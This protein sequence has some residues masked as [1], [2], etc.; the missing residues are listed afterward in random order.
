MS[1]RLRIDSDYPYVYETHLHT[2]EGSKCA[3]STGKEMADACFEA[4]YTG[5]MVT[6]HFYY[7]NTAID[8][9]L[10]W[11]DWV[12]EYCR[13]YEN[14][15]EEGDK[16]GLQV[17]FGWESTY[18]GTDFLIYGLDKEWLISH[19]EIRDASIREQFKLVHQSGGIVI[20]AHPYREDFYI[21]GIKLYPDYIDAV[22]TVNATHNSK[23]SNNHYNPEF[24]IKAEIYAAQHNFPRTAGSDVHSNVLLFGGVACKRRLNSLDDYMNMV[25]NRG[26]FKLLDGSRI[27][28]D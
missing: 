19:P 28:E 3:K 5:I 7:G 20:H 1:V 12:S 18:E 9:S 14:A 4:G 25:V 2:S 21:P 15:K 16:I 24:D 11:E 22:E 6:D 17:F 13:G 8:K 23:F 26:D 27:I 10:S